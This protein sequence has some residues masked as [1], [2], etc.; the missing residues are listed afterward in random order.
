[1]SDGAR[2]ARIDELDSIGIPG[3]ARWRLVRGALG[4]E[5]FGVNAWTAT[6][7]GQAVIGEHDEL[8]P[9]AGGHEELYLVVSGEATFTVD[10]H[11]IRAPAGTLIFVQDP[12]TRRGAVAS[13][14]GTTVLAVGGKAGEPFSVSPWE[15]NTMALR[16]WESEDWESAIAELTALHAEDPDSAGIAYNLACAEARAGRTD[17]A[18]AHLMRAVELHPPFAA[19]AAQDDDLASIRRDPRFPAP[20]A[21]ISRGHE[22]PPRGTPA[23]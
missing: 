5:A 13:E 10:G 4:I 11:A 17:D 3:Q 19:T 16:F 9:G 8:G 14:A 6:E 2:V 21:D 1:V 7:A 23:A 12:A 20:Q 22:P 15:R 18:L